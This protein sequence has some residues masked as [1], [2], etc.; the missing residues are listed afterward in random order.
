MKNRNWIIGLSLLVHSTLFGQWEVSTLEAFTN[1]IMASE[2]AIV[3]GS[4]FS[5]DTE[6]LFFNDYNSNEVALKLNGSIICL[7]EKEI[8]INQFDQWTIQN[9][10]FNLVIDSVQKTIVIQNPQT[11]Y[12]QRKTLENMGI[13]LNSSCTVQ[14]NVQAGM[15]KYSLMFE[16]GAKYNGC[17]I[18]FNKENMVTKYILYGGQEAVDDTDFYNPKVIQPRLEINYTNY[19]IG[20]KTNMTHFRRVED[21]IK[22]DNDTVVLQPKYAGYEL[23]DLR[24]NN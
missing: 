2:T 20:T 19:K 10:D 1:Q 6:Y 17:E 5:F 16:K 23:I 15:L 11:V 13:V 14:R 9:K 18:W 12:F 4:S 24:I 22:L 8:F 21:F 3:A 7:N